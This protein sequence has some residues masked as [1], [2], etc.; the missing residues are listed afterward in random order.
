VVINPLLLDTGT[1]EYLPEHTIEGYTNAI[2]M[3]ADFIEPDLVMTKDGFLVVRHE[4]MLSGTTN[5]SEI[6]DLPLKNNQ[7]LDGKSVTDWFVSDFTL[8]K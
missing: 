4:P 7:N 1:L 3:G 5:V 6:P 2:K 8:Q